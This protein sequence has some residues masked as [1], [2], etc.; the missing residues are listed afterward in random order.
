MVAVSV[1]VDTKSKLNVRQLEMS[2]STDSIHFIQYFIL[3]RQTYL[4]ALV[5]KVYIKLLKKVI[6]KQPKGFTLCMLR[7]PTTQE[8]VL[9]IGREYT[10]NSVGRQAIFTSGTCAR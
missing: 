5:W 8:H 6:G 10:K 2:V 3:M 1:A 9:Q 7:F 4:S